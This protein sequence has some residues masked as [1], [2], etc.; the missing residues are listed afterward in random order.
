MKKNEEGFNSFYEMVRK[1]SEIDLNYEK[2]L[3]EKIERKM[4]SSRKKKLFFTGVAFIV[5]LFLLVS[6]ITPVFG[7]NGTLPQAILNIRIENKTRDYKGTLSVSEEILKGVQEINLPLSDSILIQAVSNSGIAI[8]EIM[9]MR[10]EGYGWGVIFSK[11][12]FSVDDLEKNLSEILKSTRE[13]LEK[14]METNTEL[15]ND[16][17]ENKEQNLER[18]REQ[19]Y[20][21]IVKGEIKEI[22]IDSIIVDSEEIYV[23]SDTIIKY[24]GDILELNNLQVGNNVLIQANKVDGKLNAIL[25]NVLSMNR[26]NN[27]ND[28]NNEGKSNSGKNEQVQTFVINGIVEE[29]GTDYIKVD[30]EIVRIT[31]DTQIKKGSSVYKIEDIKLGDK[32]NAK[33]H[34]VNNVFVAYEINLIQASN[35]EENESTNTNEEENSENNNAN[36]T[37]KKEY[38]LRTYIVDFS[39]NILTLKDFDNSV[40]VNAETN[41]QKEGEGRVDNSEIAKGSLVQIHIREDSQGF[42]ATNI[43][44]LTQPNYKKKLSKVKLYL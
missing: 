1:N 8:S 11:Y 18:N 3:F 31:G 24:R 27:S 9:S 41:I 15:N 6:F 33:T 23:T 25:I 43:V 34:K 17:K 29:V 21:L 37:S 13:N 38:E 30:D 32:V 5:S 42:I 26:Q 7:R 44:I 19:N 12:N 16:T 22:K 14:N 36:E 20:Y 2:V 40:I 4:K 35:S 39:S 10:E 28:E